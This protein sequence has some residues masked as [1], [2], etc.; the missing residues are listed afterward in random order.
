MWRTAGVSARGS[1]PRSGTAWGLRPAASGLPARSLAD[2]EAFFRECF[3]KSAAPRRKENAESEA[4][5]DDTRPAI[6]GAANKDVAS[7]G[8]S[9]PSKFPEDV[10]GCALFENQIGKVLLPPLDGEG[11][12]RRDS[13]ANGWGDSASYFAL[14]PTPASFARRPS[15]QGGG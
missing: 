3:T 6:T 13:Y 4:L 1:Q 10:L 2:G 8:A 12:S 5:R 7:R 11:S 15:P 14:T 9:Q